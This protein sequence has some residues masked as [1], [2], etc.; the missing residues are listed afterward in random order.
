MTLPATRQKDYPQ[1][2]QEVITAADMAETSSV[3]GCMVIKPWGYGIWERLRDILDKKI[4][5]TGHENAYFPLF[6]PLKLFE[7]EANHVE[8]FAKEMAVVTHSRLKLED[9]AFKLDGKLEEPLVVRP[10]SEMIISEC[11]ANWI[12]S[13]RDLPVLINQWANVVRWEMR[14]R[15]FMRTSEFL[16]QEGHTAHATQQEAEDETWLMTE[17]YRS[18]MEDFMA[19]PV[20]IGKKSED[21]KFAGAEFTVTCESMTQDGRAL[22]MGTSH[23]LGQNFAK[24]SNIRYQD[25]NGDMQHV[26]TTSWGVSTRMIGG[27]IMTHSDDIG[28]RLPPKIAPKQIVIVPIIRE[29]TE[30]S[31]MIYARDLEATLKTL[32]YDNEPVRVQVDKRDRPAPDKKWDWV[33]KGVP[34]LIEVGPRD[35]ENNKVAVKL[36]TSEN[37]KA[38]F[39]DREEFISKV[40]E[41]LD[42]VQQALHQ[43]AIKYRDAHLRT[44]I[45]D[46]NSFSKYFEP[47]NEFLDGT[48][49]PVGFV[50]AP[51]SGDIETTT[52]ALKDLA[53]TIRC[54]PLDQQENLGPC[55]ITGKPAVTEAVFGRN[56]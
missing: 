40:P 14:T 7:K 22:Q 31:V 18:L 24:A 8:G 25:K 32:S 41:L 6:I 13:Y 44:D 5:D 52:A 19:I 1:W 35:I 10:T 29:G 47:K 45:R 36:R 53:V 39:F 51:W 26:H 42:N 34:I 11:F 46:F 27:L 4:K 30:D 38:D 43:Q 50:R 48:K 55:V 56:Y 54:L 16:W 2:Y 17:Q 3:R 28:L 21:E 9:G 12:Q 33:K 37:P 23:Y 15:L 20:I 49:S